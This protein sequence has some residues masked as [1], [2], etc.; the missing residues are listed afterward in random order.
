MGWELG[1][2]RMEVGVRGRQIV[3]DPE[4]NRADVGKVS[5]GMFWREEKYDCT[6]L[7]ET[8]SMPGHDPA[9]VTFTRF[10]KP[11]PQDVQR[12]GTVTE[13]ITDRQFYVLRYI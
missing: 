11:A 5:H 10:N 9:L 7:P 12:E 13:A 3:R 2:A 4:T 1:I 6:W 8:L